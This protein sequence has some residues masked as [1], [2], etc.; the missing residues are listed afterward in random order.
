MTEAKI[1]LIEKQCGCSADGGQCC[2]DSETKAE[3]KSEAT[4]CSA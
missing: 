1:E 4:C 2:S 3:T